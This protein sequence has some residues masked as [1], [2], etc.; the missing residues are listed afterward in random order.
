M[1]TALTIAGADPSG[2][3][4]IQSDIAAFRA[5]GVTPLSV[6]TALTAQNGVKVRSV[7][8]VPARFVA[9]QIDVLLEEF[10]VD[11]VKIGMIGSSENAAAPVKGATWYGCKE[12]RRASCQ[13]DS[14]MSNTVRCST[15]ARTT[16]A[17]MPCLPS[18]A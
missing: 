4:G 1:R 17:S 12:G 9:R 5:F 15:A 3:A 11:S 6:I 14:P 8:P 18:T 16:S 7:Q 13:S 10:S 2:G